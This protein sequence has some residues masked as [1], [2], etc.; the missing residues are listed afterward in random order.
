[1]KKKQALIFK[2]TS[3]KTADVALKEAREHLNCGRGD[4]VESDKNSI[5]EG[6]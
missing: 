3:T 2:K 6:I 1:M 4:R 5:A